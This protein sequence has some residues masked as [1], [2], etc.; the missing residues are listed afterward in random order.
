[1]SFLKTI[2]VVDDNAVNRAILS[3]ILSAKYAVLEAENG[4][5]ALEVLREH[6]DE[7]AAIMLDIMMPVM[8]GYAFLE[9]VRKNDSMS[10]LPIV[11]TTDSSGTDSELKALTL[12]AWDFVSK[13]YNPEIIMFRLKNAIDRSQ[14]SALK[15]LKYLAEYDALTGIY[16]KD[17]F[18]QVTRELLD[19]HPEETFVFMRFDVDRFQLINSFF[20]TAEGDKLLIYIAENMAKDAETCANATY[21]RIESDVVGLC[22]PYCKEQVET[23]VQ[24]SKETLAKFNPNY[25][26]VPSVGLY[27]ID[28]PSISV[29][30]MYNRATLA[31]KTC[32]GNYVEFYAYYNESMSAALA[33]EQEITNDMNGALKHGQFEIYLQPK[34]NI[35]TN[36]PCGAEALVRWRHPKKGMLS[37]A[38]FIPVFERN[39]FITKLDYYVWEQTCQRIHSWIVRGIQPFPI[40]VNVSRV[41]IYNPKLVDILSELV[42]RY[43]LAPALLQ[44]EL[45]ESAYTDNPIAMKKT[46]EQ[47]Q[48][49]GFT[50]LMDDFGSGYSS[51]S[52]LKDISVDILK[53]D[54]RFLTQNGVPGRGENIIAS[55]IRMAKWLNIPVIAE[56]A[57]TMEQVDFLRSVGCDYVQ[58]YF[59]AR[60]MPVKEYEQLCTRLAR[61][62]RTVP[63]FDSEH[64][65]YDDLFSL[66]QE[67]QLLFNNP[68]QAAVIYEFMDDQVELIRVNEAYYALLGHADMLTKSSSFFDSI[69]MT[70]RASL[71]EAF[72]TCQITKKAVECEY[73]RRRANGAPLWIFTKLRYV[74][75]VGEKHIII[76][77]LTDITI[78]KE[79]AS[80]LQKYRTSLLDIKHDTRTVLIVDDEPINRTILKQILRDNFDFFEASNG[81]EAIEVLRL[82]PNEID[83]ILLDIT[84]PVM[85][86]TEF[87]QYKKGVPE[88]D[89][90]PVII[91][92]ADDSPKQQV[93]TFSLGA[94]DYLIKPFIPEVVTRRVQ[95][96]MDSNHRFKELVREYNN[97]SEQ[98]K[99]DLMTGL[100]NRYSAEKM[101]SNRL[102]HTTGTCVMVM[103]DIDNFKCL[104]DT[105]GH[106]FGDQVVA[107]VAEKLRSSFRQDDII[108]RMGGDEFAV[109]VTNIPNPERVIFKAKTLCKT[110]GELTVEGSNPHISCSFGVAISSPTEHSFEALYRNADKALYRAKAKGRSTVEVYGQASAKEDGHETV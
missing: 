2:L 77:E 5:A 62:I 83:L 90:L 36:L 46:M 65:R 91:I 7:I 9:A 76:G 94:N 37:P 74:S 21:G 11:V 63:N 61:A 98:V 81:A 108:A 8:D 19:Q 3:N 104:N 71:L 86:G 29:E 38:E 55:V 93:N 64:Y 53:I 103:L 12:G 27:V 1:M 51:L 57:E 80:E 97:M 31:A 100:I 78:R 106:A 95:N 24:Q 101:I 26:I 96:V 52:L 32:K 50:I 110:I 44:L 45:T 87:L 42:E 43:D 59:Y 10:N 105:K 14:L 85:D 30:E 18:F 99:T 48:N 70:Y 72:H 13:P 25:D 58:G 102:L 73:M 69:D 84:M 56:G 16:N 28:D 60:P 20:G 34:Y 107:V 4:E 40:S 41:N 66:N 67:M 35:H 82:H 88:L 75:T 17:K 49:R 68:L 109:F 22:L 89:G 79:I 6:N 47:L 54:M 15:Q 92:T 23:M 33:N 39:G